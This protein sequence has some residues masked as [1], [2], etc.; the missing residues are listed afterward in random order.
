MTYEESRILLSQRLS[1][2]RYEHSLGVAD[3]AGKLARRFGV[4]AEKARLAGLLHDNAREFP[5]ADMIREASLRGIPVTPIDQAMPLL[6]H[7]PLGA[8]RLREVYDVA[9][10]EIARAVALH[11]VGGAAMTPL[12]QII[13]FADMIEPGRSYPEVSALRALAETGTLPE[14]MLEALSQSILYVVGKGHLVHPDTVTAR[15]EILLSGALTKGDS[16]AVP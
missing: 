4:D 12:D 5:V 6:L 11:T 9:D 7:A 1:R 2:T 14:I 10:E 15:N 16:V 8:H 3:T 13:Y